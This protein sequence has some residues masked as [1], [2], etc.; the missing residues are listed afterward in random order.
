MIPEAFA[1]DKI[2]FDKLRLALGDS[3]DV[4]RER[5]GLTWPGKA[6]AMRAVQIPATGTLVPDRAESVDFDNTEH[7]F[8]EGDNLEVLKL[9]QKSYHGKV[10]L[11]Y[12]DPPYNT[13]KEFIYPDNY[14]EGLEDYL[15]FSGQVGEGG[16]RMSANADTG[17]RYHSKWLSMMWP[18][19]FMAR[20][21]LREDGAIFVS[22]DDSE[23]AKLR[24]IMDD[25]FGEENFITEMVW[26][27]ANKNDARQIGVCHEYVLV[28]ARNRNL[29]PPEWQLHKEGVDLVLAEVERLRS[30]HGDNYRAAS[31]ALAGWFRSM[32]AS[33]AFGLR[34]FHG[35]DKRGAYKEDD[36]TAPGGRKFELV[37]PITKEILPLRKN[38]G[39]GFD[40]TEF[41]RLVADER[42]TFVGPTSVMVRRYLH[43][44]DTATPQSVFYQPARSA[45]ERLGRLMGAEVFSFPKDET[46]LQRFM[47]MACPPDVRQA[48][49]L[50]FF[51]GSGTTGHA[52]MAQNLGDGGNRRFIL[53]QL[54]EPLDPTNRA[55]NTAAHF[56]DS[57]GKPRTLAEITKERLRRAAVKIRSES[58]LMHG[59]LGFRAFRLTTSNFRPW[60]ADTAP[61][62]PAALAAQIDLFTDHLDPARDEEA[63][64]FEIFLRRGIALSVGVTDVELADTTWHTVHDGA[65]WISAS[66]AI[67]RAAFDAVLAH[68]PRP[69]EVIV[70]DQAFGDDQTK[71]N[72]VQQFF[73][74]QQEGVPADQRIEI[75]VL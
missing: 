13:G 50:D 19:L 11:I 70:L 17:G 20:N 59:D 45:S 33:P 64:L 56:C 54:P 35:I 57:L 67:P 18:R 66:R 43:E 32:K 71:A 9:L 34:R 28:Y 1:D 29:L 46:V 60:N 24:A 69:Q 25:I 52:V 58:P 21:L 63:I 72:V 15:K 7:V 31:T 6:D 30:V 36:P 22:I 44:T 23:V 16:A 27:G 12:I 61:T 65:I 55:P 37:N 53:V 62:D 42:V 73:D 74:T 10:K 4:G 39:W 2:D 75:K 26:E 8:I 49:V 5:Y 48:I 68:T 47:E 14:R 40:Q 41:E 51:A 3:V 38:R